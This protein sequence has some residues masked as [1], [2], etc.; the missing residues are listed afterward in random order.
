MFSPDCDSRC[1]QHGQCVNGTCQC[2]AG[3][4]GRHCTF[5][6]FEKYFILLHSVL[7]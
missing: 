3:W 4:N 5:E 2:S 6:G 7:S 1:L